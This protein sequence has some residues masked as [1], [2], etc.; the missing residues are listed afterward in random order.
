MS[1]ML[2]DVGS[3]YFKVSTKKRIEHHFRNF[4]ISIYDDLMKKCGP[5][6]NGYDKEN[7]YICSSANGGLS[8]LIIGITE[9]FS[10]KYATNIAY[11][12]GINI[13]ETILYKNISTYA[14]PK[15]H[16][17]VV[18]IV[19]G[20]DSK[21]NIF[22][23][24]LI[25]YLEQITY[26]NIVYVGSSSQTDFLTT[27]IQNLVVLPNII[28]NKLKMYEDDLKNYLTNL[29]ASDIEGKKDIKDLYK[30]TL[31]Q[32][33]STPYIVNQ[34]L[35]KVSTILDVIDP[36]IV[37]DIGGATTD[38]HYSKELVD[39]NIITTNE[40]DRLVFKKLGVYKSADSLVF[41]AKQ[42]EFVYELLAYLNKT[43]NILEKRDEEATRLLMQLAIF[44]VLYKVSHQHTS[45]LNIKLTSLNSIVLTG[46]ISKVLSD[47]EINTIVEF[48]Y[49][50][51]LC[52]HTF[53]NV[54]I[55]RDYA[56]WTLAREDFN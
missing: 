47:E 25:E 42:N 52:Y 34:A 33:Y 18:I 5:L 28:D 31:N 8:T 23:K 9:S 22:S 38:I 16:I 56:V 27:Y 46:G 54:V 55:D 6:I 51:I 2:I 29:Y 4:Q 39:D 48:F 36:F 17:D 53:P 15:E 1:K 19:G 35:P 11:N 44:L 10:L 20:I 32:I 14:K 37:I 3:T 50:K 45:Y 26:S 30:L 12:S 24:D 41:S 43:E 21:K 13:I 40:Y 49:K 7:I